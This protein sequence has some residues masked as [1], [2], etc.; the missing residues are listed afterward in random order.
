M[1]RPYSINLE[2][3][4]GFSV[5]VA[6]IPNGFIKQSDNLLFFPNFFFRKLRRI[7]GYACVFCLELRKDNLNSLAYFIYPFGITGYP[8]GCPYHPR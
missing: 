3:P 7:Y 8:T 1:L 5:I 4:V 6:I 2:F